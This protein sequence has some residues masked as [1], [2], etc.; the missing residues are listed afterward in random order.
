[1]K[2]FINLLLL[3]LLLSTFSCQAQKVTVSFFSK[4]NNKEISFSAQKDGKDWGGDIHYKADENVQLNVVAK[5]EGHNWQGQS[6][7]Q[8]DRGSVNVAAER[9]NGKLGVATEVEG[10]IKG[11]EVGTSITVGEIEGQNTLDPICNTADNTQENI[12]DEPVID[13]EENYTNYFKRQKTLPSQK[14]AAKVKS[15]RTHQ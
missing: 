13:A 1:M 8:I 15:K 4:K 11:Y 6:N 9:N 5:R 2:G 14:A 3:P 12:K 10:Q 7:L